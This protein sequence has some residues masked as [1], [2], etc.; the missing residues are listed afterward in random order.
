MTNPNLAAMLRMAGLAHPYW[1]NVMDEAAS[2]LCANAE[3]TKANRQSTN[4]VRTELVRGTNS[5]QTEGG[6]GVVLS[7]SEVPLVQQNQGKE[8]NQ[9]TKPLPIQ[10]EIR[11]DLSQ[12][13]T[14]TVRTPAKKTPAAHP[15]IPASLDCANFRAEWAKWLDFRKAKGKPVSPLAAAEQFRLCEELGPD[16]AVQQI[17][18]SIRNDW[19]GLF[20][21][22]RAG[23][24][25]TIAKPTF[26]PATFKSGE[27]KL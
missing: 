12:P 23:T 6:G 11:A 16:Q 13:S 10:P 2:R 24:K 1:A 25:P 20:K 17:R 27:V 4:S 5:A 9:Q 14:H 3:R 26:D 19:Q 21:P 18:A 7:G 22:D 8:G 15:P